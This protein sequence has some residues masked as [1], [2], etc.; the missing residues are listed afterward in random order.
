MSEGRR[1]AAPKDVPSCPFAR[2]LFAL[3]IAMPPSTWSTWPVM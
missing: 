3:Y 1:G 2:P